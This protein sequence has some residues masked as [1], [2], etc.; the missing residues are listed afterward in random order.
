MGF[1][2]RV[3]EHDDVKQD[4]HS[5][6]LSLHAFSDLSC[7]SPVVFLFLLKESYIYGKSKATKK[8]RALQQQVNLALLNAP[9]PGP[10]VFIVRCLYVLP[11]FE[12]YADG[13]SH[14]I[15]SALRKFLKTNTNPTDLLEAQDLAAQLFL[16]VV[17]GVVIHDERIL[18]KLIEAVDVKLVNVEKA[19][20]NS[21]AK[22]CTYD[23]AEA[24]MENYIHQHIESQSYM[25]AVSLLEQFDIHHSGEIL[26]FKILESKDFRA[27]EKWASYVGKSMLCILVQEYVK[28]NM[29]KPAYGIIKRNNLQE[30]FP[31]VYHKCKESSL[32]TLAEKGCWDVAEERTEN[33][34]QLLEYLVYLAMEAGYSEKVDEL[35]E[36][37]SLEGFVKAKEPEVHPLESRYLHLHELFIDDIIWVDEADSLQKATSYIEGCK[38]VGVDCE[39]KPNYVKGSKGNKVSIMQIASEK[40]AFIFDLIKLY[41]DA[42]EVLNNCLIRI[43]QSPRILKLGYNFQCDMHQL[44]HSYQKLDCFKRY[45]MLLDIQKVFNEPCGGLSGLV[46]KILGTGLNKTR[47]NSNWELRP[48]SQQQLEYAALDAVVLVHLFHHIRSHSQ[49]IDVQ[50]KN[51]KIEWKSHIVSASTKSNESLFKA[52]TGMPI[53]DQ[54]QATRLH[55]LVTQRCRGRKILVLRRILKLKPGIPNCPRLITPQFY[56]SPIP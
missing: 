51:V 40:V 10:A 21:A 56:M 39:W 41:D 25:T 35:C 54:S 24:F 37:Y 22:N 30:E 42:P 43:L 31:D 33:D 20:H 8:F 9:H 52:L 14:L 23:K 34:R 50:D 53:M 18:L 15:V 49:P 2:E 29:L 5:G 13:F 12:S 46:K 36:R 16:D 6:A 4:E 28:M 1:Q 44:A 45:E 19:I 17:Q 32:K 47:R 55:T 38:V 7:V 11:V 26:L 3:V 27:A 48:L